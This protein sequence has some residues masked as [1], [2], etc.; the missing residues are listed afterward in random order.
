MNSPIA[1]L[2]FQDLRRGTDPFLKS[3]FQ[4]I[5]SSRN[6]EAFISSLQKESMMRL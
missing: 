6:I 4:S 3:V 5:V 1:D 2:N